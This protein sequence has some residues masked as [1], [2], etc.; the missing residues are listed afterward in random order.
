MDK[1]AF[2]SFIH[3]KFLANGLIDHGT[4]TPPLTDSSLVAISKALANAVYDTVT[5]APDLV[6]TCTYSGLLGTVAGTA[7]GPVVAVEGA[8][9]ASVIGFCLGVQGV[10][11]ATAIDQGITQD[12]TANAEAYINFPPGVVVPGGPVATPGTGVVAAGGMV[13]N[14]AT[15]LANMQ[16]AWLAENMLIY[17][18]WAGFFPALAAGVVAAMAVATAPTIP[19]LGG[20]PVAPP[21]PV[22]GANVTTLLK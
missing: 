19:V 21:A 7:L 3:T 9:T 13:L 5:S 8:I 10:Q 22:S 18:E 12:V 2:A 20:T 4:V 6:I 1:A 14:Y 17:G 16:S 11:F 15:M